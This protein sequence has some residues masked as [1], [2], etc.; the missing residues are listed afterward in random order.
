MLWAIRLGLFT[1]ILASFEGFAMTSMLSHTV[2]ASDGGPGLP[3]INW[4]TIAGDL[5]VA[6][7]LGM[8]GLQIFPLFAFLLTKV[9]KELPARARTSMVVSF[10]ILYMLL[11]NFTL[12]Q[13][14]NKIPLIR[15]QVQVEVAA[16]K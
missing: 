7:F 10:S 3:V 12:W 13:A 8:H 5:R 6:H 2:G 11:M 16:N 9:N 15:I 14:L 1:M 4:S